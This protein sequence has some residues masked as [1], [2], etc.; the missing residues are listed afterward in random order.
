MGGAFVAVADDPTAAFA[1]P[2]GLPQMKSWQIGVSGK[3][4][5]FE[6]QLTTANYL[7][8]PS[9]VFTQTGLDV[10]EPSASVNA[11]EF[12]SLGRP[13]RTAR[14]PRALPGRQPPVPARRLRPRG[15]ELQ[16]LLRQ[17]GGLL[18]ELG[19]R[20]GG[21]RHPERDVRRL[22][23]LRPGRPL[24]RRRSHVQP[25]P[26]RPDRGKRGR[27]PHLH[28]QRRQRG[29]G[30]RDGPAARH[31]REVGGDLGDPPG[32]DRGFSPP[33][34]R[35]RAHRDRGGLPALS[36]LRPQLHVQRALAVQPQPEGRLLVRRGRP[37]RP[38]ERR[39]RLRRLSRSRRLLRR[40]LGGPF[41]G[42]P[43][44]RR[45]PADPLLPAQRR[46]RADLRLL[47]VHR[48]EP[49]LLDP[50]P[51]DPVGLLRGRNARALRRRVHA[52]P[53]LGDPGQ[54]PRGLLP[55]ARPR[56]PAHA[57]RGREPGP[58][59]PTTSRSPR[60]SSTRRSARRS[61]RATA[62]ARPRTTSPAGSGSPSGGASPWTS[63][64]TWGRPPGSS[65]SRPSTASGAR[66][67]Q[68]A[69][70]SCR[71]AGETRSESGATVGASSR[72]RACSPRALSRSGSERRPPSRYSPARE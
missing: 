24:A 63:P 46:V 56:E 54:P 39:E 23:R 36:R 47:G 51:D 10:Y 72:A 66:R 2:S 35:G 12:L 4:F 13:G 61:A 69:A 33:R 9:G 26:V 21:A 31:D 32:L 55:G 71:I 52:R 59:A 45:G 44:G 60:T 5:S 11:L 67:R 3:G 7:E 37:E 22:P 50:D 70:R 34:L 28:H 58:E 57:L 29:H 62:A 20:A 15:R 68:R 27:S 53:L 19:R 48:R 8:S 42:P 43:A 14:D 40:R 64:R 49:L 6:P 17:P 18:L 41:R 65:S 1:N 38:R 25:A 30:S 16:D